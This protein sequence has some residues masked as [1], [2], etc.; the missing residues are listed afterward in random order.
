MTVKELKE[1]L[2][3]YHDSTELYIEAKIGGR[4][5]PINGHYELASGIVLVSI[6]NKI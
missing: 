5:E 3:E 2:N 6:A 4:P 1:L